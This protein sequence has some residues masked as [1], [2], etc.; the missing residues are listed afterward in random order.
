[1]QVFYIFELVLQLD[2]L[3]FTDLFGVVGGGVLSLEFVHDVRLDVLDVQSL[4]VV[5]CFHV[6]RELTQR[7]HGTPTTNVNVEA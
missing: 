6:R 1:M 3:L 4:I 7:A 2:E 5:G